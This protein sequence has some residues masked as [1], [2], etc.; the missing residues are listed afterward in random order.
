MLQAQVQSERDVIASTGGSYKSVSLQVDHTVGE[1]VVSTQ[2]SGDIHLSQGFHQY[3]QFPN[4][5]PEQDLV[6]NF[7]L[8]PNPVSDELTISFSSSSET[9]W[10]I[11]V[12]DLLGQLIPGS[13]E[14]V[15]THG[16]KQLTIDCSDYPPG[17]YFVQMLPEGANRKLSYKFIKTK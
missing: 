12:A 10:N 9:T 13:S 3:I 6:Q 2:S 15:S 1:L 4:A 7:N 16:K 8:Y 14:Q 5:I 17:I 11:H